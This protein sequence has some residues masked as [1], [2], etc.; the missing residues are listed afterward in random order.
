MRTRCRLKLL[1]HCG[2]ATGWAMLCPCRNDGAADQAGGGSG[3]GFEGGEGIGGF[4]ILG[5]GSLLAHSLGPGFARPSARSCRGGWFPR[6]RSRRVF[7][8]LQPN[9]GAAFGA[10]RLVAVLPFFKP[11]DE[12]T[13]A[14]SA[15]RHGRLSGRRLTP[16]YRRF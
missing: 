4:G 6:A 10:A 5:A 15:P 8:Q 1:A 2:C 7:L 11:E 9:D 14:P 12:P 16:S 13:P 3:R